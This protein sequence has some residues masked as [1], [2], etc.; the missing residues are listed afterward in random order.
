MEEMVALKVQ[1]RRYARQAAREVSVHEQLR[2]AGACLEIAQLR[3]AFLHDG[4]V[5]MAYDLY[6][7]NLE[8]ALDA[9]PLPISRVRHAT[10]QLLT[11]LERLH[12]CGLTHTDVKPDNILLD[13]A[14]GDVRLAD[15]GSA[16][17]K[18][19]RGAVIGT[20]EYVPP[21]AIIGAPLSQQVDIWALGCT[22]CEMLT[23]KVLFS[24][25]RAAARKYREFSDGP[26]ALVTE[27][28]PTVT[29]DE[30]EEAAEQLAEGSLV[31]GKYLVEK[32]LGCGR[33]AT[34]WSARVV[35]ATDLGTS[36]DT[37]MEFARTVPEEDDAEAELDRQAS[38]WQE[39]R[40][41]TDLLDLTLKYEHLLLIA[42][43]AGRFPKPWVRTGA[44]V[45]AY[46]EADG[47]LR[48]R[49]RLRR[50][51]LTARLSPRLGAT[52]AA[53][54]SEFLSGFFHHDPDERMTPAAA[55][56]HAWLR[57]P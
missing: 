22:L 45:A 33:F 26:D 53:A 35:A 21:E 38:E 57:S 7:G 11:A 48:F 25:R 23:G 55:L 8:D 46:F 28:H 42:Q 5:C 20:R 27:L 31:A 54:A 13:P 24:P 30:A 1:R 18:L 56:H 6:G 44:F 2:E 29:R 14:T 10:R 50:R 36:A 9:G 41:A 17:T 40:G 51:S 34:V 39:A 37:L 16:K 49:P 4:H 15:L 43:L 19:R 12:R 3:E 52:E 47:E 32:V